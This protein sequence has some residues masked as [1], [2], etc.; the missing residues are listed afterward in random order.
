MHCYLPYHL[1][2]GFYQSN[3]HCK[4]NESKS[5]GDR[6]CLSSWSSTASVSSTSSTSSSSTNL[7]EESM[8]AAKYG[9]DE[10]SSLDLCLYPTKAADVREVKVIYFRFP[11][12]C[13]PKGWRWKY[14]CWDTFLRTKIGEKWWAF[15]CYTNHLVD[16]K[17]FE[18]FIIIMILGSSISLVIFTALFLRLL[19]LFFLFLLPKLEKVLQNLENKLL[20][21]CSEMTNLSWYVTLN[22]H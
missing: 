11:E 19:M 12:D 10:T 4:E 2:S 17:L 16:H 18:S 5:T 14:A 3:H 15:R 20:V 1:C 21:L 6:K 7:D 9:L 13:C 8:N 22:V